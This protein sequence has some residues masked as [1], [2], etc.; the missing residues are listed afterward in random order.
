[1][2]LVIITI[3]MC[4]VG[5][6]LAVVAAAHVGPHELDRGVIQKPAATRSGVSASNE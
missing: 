2:V 6:P 5:F 1:M 4:L 3:G